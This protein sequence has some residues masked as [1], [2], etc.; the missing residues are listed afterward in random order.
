MNDQKASENKWR[1]AAKR[2]GLILSKSRARDPWTTG[3]G[4]YRLLDALT[5][6]VIAGNNP[7]A[8]SLDLAGVKAY[9][10]RIG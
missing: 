9:L 10:R 7:H 5:H 8:Y 2:Q 4:G 1:R 3:F 6:F